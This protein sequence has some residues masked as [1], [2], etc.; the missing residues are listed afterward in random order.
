M[1]VK[2]ESQIA[3]QGYYVPFGPVAFFFK[4]FA[5]NVSLQNKI[6]KTTNKEDSLSLA[7]HQISC[8]TKLLFRAQALINV[9]EVISSAS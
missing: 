7:V 9:S 1:K 6:L 8:Y 4:S 5:P 3:N 2:A